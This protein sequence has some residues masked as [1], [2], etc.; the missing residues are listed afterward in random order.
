MNRSLRTLPL[1][2]LL[3]AFVTACGEAPDTSPT[4]IAD[5]GLAANVATPISA[6]RWA[7]LLADAQRRGTSPAI[8]APRSLGVAPMFAPGPVV[9]TNG[10]ATDC[11]PAGSTLNPAAAFVDP[12]PPASYRQCAGFTNTTSDDVRWDWENNCVSAKGG[13]LFMRVFDDASGT[14]IAGAR[15]HSGVSLVWAAGTGLNYSA[16]SY[17]GEGLLNNVPASGGLPGGVSLA[18]HASDGF[19]CGCG[20]PPGGVGT[21][22]D[23]FTANAANTKILYVGGNSSNHNYEAVW[24]PPGPKNTCALSGENVRIRVAIYAF[25]PNQPPVANAG[26]D[27]TVEA[28]GALTAVSLNGSASSDPDGDALTYSWSWSGGSASGATPTVNLPLG[29]H[30]ITLTVDD[31][32]GGT[33]SDQVVITVRDT[34]PPALS[35]ALSA[36]ELWPPDHRMVTVATGISASDAV[37]S[38]VAISISVTSNEPDNG[39]GDGDTTGDIAVIDNGNGTYDI[40]VRAERGGNGTGRVYTINVTATDDSGNS[41]TASGQVKVPHSKGKK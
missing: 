5:D 8:D 7:E 3:A 10:S 19:Y 38:S 25:N 12:S 29:T 11:N 31:G 15:L 34:T 21:C 24:G 23:I 13:P 6:A 17:E 37:D 18:W 40:Q 32:K 4:S 30:T 35:F 16:D 28:T 33:A 14:I 22:N 27:Q 1:T 2:L 36:T 26:P 41:T 20:R 39:L 9:C